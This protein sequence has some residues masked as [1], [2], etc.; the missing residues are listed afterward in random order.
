MKQFVC[1]KCGKIIEKTD[2]CAGA[3]GGTK[4]KGKEPIVYRFDLCSLCGKQ[5]LATLKI[6]AEEDN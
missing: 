5:L 2:L 3:I 1:N 6:K 4:R